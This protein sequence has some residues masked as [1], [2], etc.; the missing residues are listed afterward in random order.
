MHNWRAHP[1]FPEIIVERRG[2]VAR[3]MLVEDAQS[4]LTILQHLNE[5]TP[6]DIR[7]VRGCRLNALADRLEEILKCLN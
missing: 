6:D 7:K 4:V 5:I 3:F 2:H 1:D